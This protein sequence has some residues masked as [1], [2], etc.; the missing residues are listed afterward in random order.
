MIRSSSGGSRRSVRTSRAGFG[1][2]FTSAPTLAPSSVS[3][4]SRLASAFTSTVAE[5]STRS[6]PLS[7]LAS[8]FALTSRLT[9]PS[10]VVR[11][12]AT[13]TCTPTFVPGPG[14]VVTPRPV[15]TFRSR[16]E[17]TVRWMLSG[18]VV[19]PC[20]LFGFMV[21]RSR[22]S[23]CRSSPCAAGGGGGGGS[24]AIAE[25]AAQA[26]TRAP[27]AA[28]TVAET[29]GRGARRLTVSLYRQG[30]AEALAA[31][32]WRC[33]T[34]VTGSRGLVIAPKSATESVL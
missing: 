29:R 24:A 19:C 1:P 21:I 31:L 23:S 22:L 28:P 11:S 33:E 17:G 26:S 12:T 32:G 25:G 18:T 8:T 13:G 34:G 4:P 16:T 5:A 2:R 15:S 20:M 7:R 30:G 3:R 10:G 9:P 27:R 6:C 14:G